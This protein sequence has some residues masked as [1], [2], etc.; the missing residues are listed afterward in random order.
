MAIEIERKFLVVDMSWKPHVVRVRQLRQAY[1]A[2]DGKISVRVRIDG[3]E[4]ATLTLKTA[5]AGIERYEFEYPIP[6]AD[7]EA[8]LQHRIGS[9]ISKK[10]HIVPIGPLTWE[11]DVFEDENTGL[12]LAEVE[13][14]HAGRSIEHPAWLGEEVTHDR[15]YYNAE[16][17]T[18][19]FLRW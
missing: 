7:A 19:P 13:L 11:I 3:F 9:L 14:D 12:V 10:R 1:L 15:R 2:E 5:R 18:H 16:L 4:S 17:A 6:V 8:L